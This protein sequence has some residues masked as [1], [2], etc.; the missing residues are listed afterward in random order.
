VT[1]QDQN[2]Q[3]KAQQIDAAEIPHP[4]IEA[5]EVAEH[6][7]EHLGTER[8]ERENEKEEVQEVE[9]THT[10]THVT[11]DEDESMEDT[12]TPQPTV[13]TRQRSPTLTRNNRQETANPQP[14]Y[15]GDKAS[16]PYTNQ[17]ATIVAP[18]LRIVSSS[19]LLCQPPTPKE[20]L[21][22]C[23]RPSRKS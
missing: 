7:Q 17:H 16:I 11:N 5:A 19:E 6:P 20:R 13:E 22:S 23:S 18:S 10:H 3:Q 12:A 2:E 21:I 4:S 8:N 15:S 1:K 9:A 14:A